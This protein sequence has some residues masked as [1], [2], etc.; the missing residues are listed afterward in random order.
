MIGFSIGGFVDMLLNLKAISDEYFDV[1][2]LIDIRHIRFNF[3]NI[4][5]LVVR[6]VR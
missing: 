2:S 5:I 3:E 1:N 4:Q 6:S